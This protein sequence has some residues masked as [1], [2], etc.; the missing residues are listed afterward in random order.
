MQHQ[1]I[2]EIGVG[3]LQRLD[4]I[5]TVR[6]QALNDG[7]GIIRTSA[8]SV[9]AIHRNELDLARANLDDASQRLSAMVLATDPHPSIRTAGYVQDAMKEYSEAEILLAI[10][11]GEAVPSPE[12]LGVDDAPWLNGLA[13]AASELRRM[14]LDQLRADQFAR[15]ESL[16]A[17]MDDVY[18]FLVTVD[19]PDGVTGGL[20]RST[21]TLRAVLE[22]TRGDLTVTGAQERLRKA[23]E[24]V[25]PALGP[26]SVA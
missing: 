5:N 15:A 21:D 22:R 26:D 17:I 25:D 14:T 19:Y 23:L 16:L 12:E 10:V 8:N 7:R 20:R 6:D 1:T 4:A 2:D 9:R 18:A 3:I 24:R 11:S 13:E